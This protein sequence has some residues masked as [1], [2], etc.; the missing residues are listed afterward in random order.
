MKQ[1]KFQDRHQS[2]LTDFLKNSVLDD[3]NCETI[4]VFN[5]TNEYRRNTAILDTAIF[6]TQ[7]KT[8]GSI[9]NYW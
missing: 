9:G 2:R 8:E 6:K 7:I 3:G 4:V 1:K 5:Q